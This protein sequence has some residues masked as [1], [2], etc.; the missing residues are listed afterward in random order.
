M[1]RLMNQ[2]PPMRWLALFITAL[3]ALGTAG[4][5]SCKPGQPGPL[6]KYSI[7]V[8][9]DQPLHGG[10]VVVDL[11]GVNMST[12]RA[13]ETYSMTEYWQDKNPRR[14]DADKV[15]LDFSAAGK[16]PTVQ[17]LLVTDD[18]MKQWQARGVTH[19]LV[20]ADLPGAHADKEGASDS[21]RQVL[22][23]DSCHWA[24]GTKQLTVQ[25]KQSVIEVQTPVRA[26][27]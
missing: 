12:L 9:L 15:T 6:G 18:K 14:R 4:C 2:K 16:K 17:K 26:V 3:V 27:K 23:L 10:S 22:P 25:V 5:Q 11:V 1:K 7:E 13:W 8:T 19:V 24:K 21:R 20:L